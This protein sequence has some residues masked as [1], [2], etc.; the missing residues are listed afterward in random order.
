MST[1]IDYED[2]D[3]IHQTLLRIEALLSERSMLESQVNTLMDENHVI[4]RELQAIR[5]LRAE[6]PLP[7]SPNAG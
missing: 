6:N 1:A 4:R 3:R 2:L 5:Q 7:S